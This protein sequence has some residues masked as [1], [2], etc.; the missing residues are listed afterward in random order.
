M[1]F[2]LSLFKIKKAQLVFEGG[3]VVI[4]LYENIL[5]IGRAENS[6]KVKGGVEKIGDKITI[7]NSELARRISRNHAFLRWDKETDKYLFEDTS[8]YGSVV[9]GRLIHQGKI[10]LAD[11]DKINLQGLRFT[12]IY[13]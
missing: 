13:S 9:S 5:I 4:P 7:T 2:G 12:I 11:K 6:V 3:K 8:S 1:V 10:L